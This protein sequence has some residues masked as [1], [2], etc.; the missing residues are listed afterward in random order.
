MRVFFKTPEIYVTHQ[1]EQEITKKNKIQYE[2]KFITLRSHLPI[3]F[4]LRL[5]VSLNSYLWII[6]T[7]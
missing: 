1:K 5:H 6:Y 3:K 4:T 2:L 7:F